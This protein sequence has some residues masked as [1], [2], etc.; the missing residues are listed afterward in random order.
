M[1]ATT[2]WNCRQTVQAGA[3]TCLWCGVAQKSTPTQFVVAPDGAAAAG[4]IP[5]APVTAPG[6]QTPLAPSAVGLPRA[7]ATRPRPVPGLGASLGPA[8]RGSAASVG[9]QVAAFTVDVVL[10]GALVGG[11]WAFTQ[12]AV[13]AGIA[14]LEALVFLWVLEARTGATPG[15]ALVRLR[16]AKADAPYSPG[17]G[18][19]LVKNL[20]FGTGFLVAAVGAWAVAASGGMDS[21]GRRR[22][23]AARAAGIQP[24]A[25]PTASR[26]T[27]A[28]VSGPSVTAAPREPAPLQVPPQALKNAADV[29]Q[30]VP[31]AQPAAPAALA[32][33]PVAPAAAPVAPAVPAPVPS[34]PAPVPGL[35][36]L[37]DSV[38]MSATGASHGSTATEA[39]VHA[40]AVQ[41]TATPAGHEALVLPA[42]DDSQDGGTLLLIF[43]TGQREQ[44]PLPVA[45]NLGR[46]PVATAEGDALIAVQDPEGTVSKTHLRLEYARGRA[47]VADQGS[48]N[49]TDLIDDEGAVTRLAPH[50]RTLLEQ[51]TRVR[52]GNRAFTLSVLLDSQPSG[53]HS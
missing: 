23:L 35:G 4:A 27:G 46:K 37:E 47:W 28:I 29:L 10:V 31:G 33:A 13:W 26:P 7:S 51:G 17:I 12:S 32:A 3:A 6:V 48:T 5:P 50:T 45:V 39:G 41:P 19:V 21:T 42:A 18:R 38:S 14:L 11:I 43:D 22:S 34:L 1:S 49:G 15:A 8:F 44:L 30:A 2:C 52:I 20:V 40:H 36:A 25:I 53:A 16:F 9:A 24:V